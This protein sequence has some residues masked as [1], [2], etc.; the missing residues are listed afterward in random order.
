MHVGEAELQVLRSGRALAVSAVGQHVELHHLPRRLL[1]GHLVVIHV[2]SAEGLVGASVEQAHHCP[3]LELAEVH[4]HVGA[5]CWAKQQTLPR[6]GGRLL[7]PRQSAVAPQRGLEARAHLH[8]PRQEALLRTNHE[9]VHLVL[10]FPILVQVTTRTALGHDAELEVQE[11]RAARIQQAEAVQ[12]TLDLVHG[13]GHAVHDHD[14]QEN[15]GVPDGRYVRGLGGVADQGDVA[16][17]L[18]EG[19]GRRVEELAVLVEGAIRDGNGDLFVLPPP[20]QEVGLLQAFARPGRWPREPARHEAS[21][22]SV[23]LADQPEAC[24]PGVDVGAG[25]AQRVVV[26]PQR[27]RGL[28][29]LVLKASHARLPVGLGAELVHQRTPLHEALQVARCRQPPCIRVAVAVRLRVRSVDVHNHR[30][31]PHVRLG[32]FGILLVRGP[33][34]RLASGPL[35]ARDL[36]RICPVQRL[37]DGHDVGDVVAGRPPG[38]PPL[39][40]PGILHEVVDPAHSGACVPDSLNSVCRVVELGVGSRSNA[41]G[42]PGQT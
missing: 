26:V 4:E 14:V 28:V 21:L 34:V 36:P 23:L 39:A 7:L 33:A 13:P 10:R 3:R 37:V 15:L 11:A 29:V 1:V 30:H 17:L 18:E 32:Q 24:P 27:R 19:A 16:N 31:R 41:Q 5:L 2:E 8:H 25:D 40:L 12:V 9:E 42:A 38:L 35:F 20:W 22:A 6:R